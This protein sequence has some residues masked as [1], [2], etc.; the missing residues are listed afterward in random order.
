M[1]G[2]IIL[3]MIAAVIVFDIVYETLGIIN[4]VI[5]NSRRRRWRRLVKTATI[6]E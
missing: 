3:L 1:I 6:K 4:N 2:Q 5:E